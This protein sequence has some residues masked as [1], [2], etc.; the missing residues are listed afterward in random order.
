VLT[1]LWLQSQRTIK[2]K[3]AW[4]LTA[5]MALIAG[6]QIWNVWFPINKKLWTSSYVLFAAGCALVALAACTW[7][8]KSDDAPSRWSYPWRVFGT[9]AIAAYVLSEVL[10]IV[11]YVVHVPDGGK[12]VT[13]KGYLFE[14]FFASVFSPGM[15][16]LVFALAFVA[17]C[18]V[19][20]W[21]LFR[22]RIFIKI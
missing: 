2:E 7:L 3:S 13:L 15:D 16:S 11:I 14:H 19:P 20:V 17:V 21:I 12:Y 4:M 18:F 6:G 5:G 1:G 8:M 9:N 10:A 22:R